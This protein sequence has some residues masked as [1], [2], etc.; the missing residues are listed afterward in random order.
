MEEDD[1]ELSFIDSASSESSDSDASDLFFYDNSSDWDSE[2]MPYEKSRVCIENYC[3]RTILAY[4][5]HEFEHH[6]RLTR[7]LAN[8]IIIRFAQSRHYLDLESK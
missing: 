1:L 7:N 5:D 3:E 4:S 6:F 8:S 2:D